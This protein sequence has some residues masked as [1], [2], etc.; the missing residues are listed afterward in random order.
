MS[1]RTVRAYGQK[2]GDPTSAALQLSMRRYR[3]SCAALRASR[4]LIDLSRIGMAR[5]RIL[6][7]RQV[8]AARPP[9][10]QRHIE[11]LPLSPPLQRPRPEAGLAMNT[12]RA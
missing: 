4:L 3:R 12:A 9:V 7:E 5:C 2:P 6:L 8:S 11:L 10:D 1:W